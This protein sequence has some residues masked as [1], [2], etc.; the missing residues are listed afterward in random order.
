MNNIFWI[1]QSRIHNAG[2][3]VEAEH[4]FVWHLYYTCMCVFARSQ[5]H[6]H[7][8]SLHDPRTPHK[9]NHRI[10]EPSC[11]QTNKL[12]GTKTQKQNTGAKNPHVGKKANSYNPKTPPQN[13]FTGSQALHVG[14]KKNRRSQKHHHKKNSQ[15]RRNQATHLCWQQRIHRRQEPTT[16]IQ[17]GKWR[18]FKYLCRR[19]HT[20]GC[21]LNGFVVNN[22]VASCFTSASWRKYSI[23]RTKSP[24][25]SSSASYPS[26]PA[27]V[28]FLELEVEVLVFVVVVFAFF[29][30]LSVD[31]VALVPLALR[32]CGMIKPLHQYISPLG[33]GKVEAKNYRYRTRNGCLLWISFKK[34]E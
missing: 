19:R 1:L 9:K 23:K 4:R 20:G 12:T 30:L 11:R 28:F 3:L 18:V 10:Q 31:F 26:S 5:K 13:K 22:K 33:T 21:S 15:D 6:H 7:Q 24:S 27:L 29:D 34:Y 14:K 2:R 32:F 8:K 25:P 16:I 17:T